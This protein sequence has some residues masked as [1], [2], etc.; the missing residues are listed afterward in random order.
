LEEASVSDN[1]LSVSNRAVKE[2]RSVG[3]GE[4]GANG[5]GNHAAP[6]ELSD[7]DRAKIAELSEQIEKFSAAK[8]WSDVIKAT[9]HKAELV[10][11]PA[12]KVSLFAEA[13]RMYLER[14]SNQA[15]AI[16]CYQR[17]LE[18]DRTNVEAISHLKDMYEKRRDWE[19]LV[20]VMRIESELLDPTDQPL[21]KLEIAQ[22]ATEKVR[23]PNVCIELWRDVIAVDPGSVEAL[24][25]LS[26]LYE[27]AREWGPLAE[28]LERQSEF[29]KD[30]TELVAL[31]QKL[32]NVYAEKLNDDSNALRAY[33][34]LLELDPNDRRAQE[35]LKKRWVATGAWDE[36]EAFYSTTDKIDELI[37]TI[38]RAADSTTTDLPQRIALQFR[39]ARL[40]LDKKNAADRV[41]RS[42]S[43]S[44]TGG[45]SKSRSAPAGCGFAARAKRMSN[46]PPARP[47]CG[48]SICA[49]PRES[50]RA[51][52]AL[53]LRS[54]SWPRRAHP[55]RRCMRDPTPRRRPESRR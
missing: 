4:N 3:L 51:R 16:K 47:G 34:R 7:S 36:L 41:P 13:G 40:W 17:V 50:S 9:I 19:R 29:A 30:N 37:R 8:R 39:I 42:W 44:R 38:E 28:V 32:G 26:G 20:E 46:C 10:I 43:R 27:R 14:S 49:R 6:L 53:R 2:V 33:K 12:E 35:Q 54:K 23:K 22:M 24:T 25:A 15:D 48:L 1:D 45:R 52:R 55:R 11:E 5:N 21:R 31:L 18:F